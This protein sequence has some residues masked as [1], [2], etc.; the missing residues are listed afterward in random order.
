MSAPSVIVVGAG[1]AGLACAGELGRRGV[2]AVVLE[3]S[4]GVGGRC[5]TRRVLDEQPV[6][7]GL[8]FF[9]MRSHEFGVALN[10]LGE[11]GKLH[12]W[13]TDVLGRRLACQRAAFTPGSK[14]WARAEGVNAFPKLLARGVDV[15]RE[16]R[17]VALR[18][19]DAGVEVELEDGATLAAPLVVLALP[20]PRSVALAAPLAA[21][22]PRARA[23]LETLAAIEMVSTV[24]VIAGYTTPAF[25]PLHTLWYPIET[26]MLHMLSHDSSKRPKP[27]HEV[28]VLHGRPAF[29]RESLER[30]AAEWSGELL[31]E[32]GELLGRWAARPAWTQ[33]HV[34]R[35]ARVRECDR[36]EDPVGLES[37]R[38]ARLA[39]IGDAFASIGGLEGAY[40]SGIQMGEQIADLP[41]VPRAR[42][43]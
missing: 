30:P 22:W 7:H 41:D 32:A 26:T 13:P 5:A 12:G 1:V 10:A 6:D 15:R 43:G 2:P 31:W 34:W 27:R 14:R 39:L 18:E 16:S 42:V 29:S 23:T 36:F 21:D 11:S 17:V 3:R 20:V 37:P 4:R 35:H 9:H 33:S 38:G 28:L 25:D 24:A 19:R 40:L 8:P